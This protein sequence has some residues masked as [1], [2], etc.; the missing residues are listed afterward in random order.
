[1]F[2]LDS[3]VFISASRLYY[4]PIIA[5]TFWEWL[6]DQHE[7]GNLASIAKVYKE[8][9]DG[10]TG[11]L[12]TWAAKLP[13]SFW[14]QPNNA[15]AWVDSPEREYRQAAREEFLRIA[16]YYLVAQAHAGKHTVVTSELPAPESKKRILIP[17]A[18]NAMNVAYKE[19]FW[20]YRKLGLRFS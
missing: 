20:V 16:D 3:N 13:S 7:Q 15:T 2:L 18:C 5:P 4:A 17:D 14:L 8:I 1:M 10:E 12:K 9:D 19:P 11:H 6:K